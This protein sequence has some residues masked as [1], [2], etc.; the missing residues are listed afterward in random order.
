MERAGNTY[1]ANMTRFTTASGE[2]K[3]EKNRS[4]IKYYT[5]DYT[6]ILIGEECILSLYVLVSSVTKKQDVL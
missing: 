2:Q 5:L 3:K 4:S 1:T 6:D